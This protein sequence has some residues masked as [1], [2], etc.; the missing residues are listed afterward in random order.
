MRGG[1]QKINFCLNG[2]VSNGAVVGIAIKRDKMPRHIPGLVGSKPL[3]HRGH[4][5]HRPNPRS[6]TS[7]LRGMDRVLDLP[8]LGL[9]LLSLD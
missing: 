2:V 1:L 5:D 8:Y 7:G 9:R 6:L 4:R 3:T